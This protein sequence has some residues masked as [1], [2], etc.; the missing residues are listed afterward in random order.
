[1]SLAKGLSILFIFSK[2]QLF[3]SLIFF[4]IVLS[5]CISVLMFMSSFFLLTSGFVCSYSSCFRYKIRF[6]ISDFSC[7]LRL[8]CIAINFPLRTAFADSHRF[9]IIMLLFS[10][11]SMYLFISSDFFSDPLVSSST[12]FSLHVFVFCGFFPLYLI[13]NLRVVV[14]KN[15]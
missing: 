5:V 8:D 2:N 3:V 4:P 14:G 7:F 1:M 12:F 13:S 15:A 10:F 6:F 9:W 11:V